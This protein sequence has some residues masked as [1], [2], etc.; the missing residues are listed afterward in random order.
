MKKKFVLIGAGHSHLTF[1]KNTNAGFFNSFS[2]TLIETNL[3]LIYSGMTP[4]YILGNY[5]LDNIILTRIS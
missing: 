5:E 3:K 2:I 1:L 4:G